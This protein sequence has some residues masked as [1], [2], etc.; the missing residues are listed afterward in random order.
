VERK[1]PVCA[2]VC[3]GDSHRAET[4]MKKADVMVS[5][6]GSVI[7]LAPHFYNTP[8][9]VE[10]ALDRLADVYA[11]PELAASTPRP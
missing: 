11:S 3:P 5:A 10:I 6:R 7:R 4:L 2:F 8:E 9:E 1:T